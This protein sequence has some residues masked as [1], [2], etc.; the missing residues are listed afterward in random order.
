MFD[1]ITV[2]SATV[3]VFAETDKK[4]IRGNAYSFPIGTK[5]LVK[6]LNF[7]T[8]GGGT[9][10]AV[11]LARLGNKVAFIGKI[12]KG[13]NSE[14]IISQLKKEG[15]NTTLICR[16]N[17][18]TG[19][20][21]ILDAKGTDRTILVFKGSNN[22]L[23]IN[24]IKK[25]K[26]KTKWFYFSS[27]MDKAFRTQ[28]QLAE[29]ASKHNIKIAYNPSSY[30]TKKGKDYLKKILSRTYLLILNKEE[31][32]MLVSGEKIE[33]MM[34]A[35]LKLGPKIAVV[36]DGKNGAYSYD[37]KILCRAIPHDVEI[38]ET[39]GAGDAFASSFLSG[40]IKKNDIEFALQL[41]Q[42]NAESVITHVGAKNILLSY[43]EALKQI[44][45]HPARIIKKRI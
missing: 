8:G 12:G 23:S 32:A 30:L 17:A 43:N 6:S 24:E 44:K 28:E 14:R 20:S 26:L 5:L 27:M 38:V 2:G 19:F 34:K 3:D 1:V 22:D 4:F 25:S 35:L 10:T 9:N 18:R 21:V 40:I 42:T 15:V 45:A 7:D 39:T 33:L 41:G 13:M 31:A 11:S 36:T 16:E 37:G 29:F